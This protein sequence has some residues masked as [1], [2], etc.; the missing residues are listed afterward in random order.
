MADEFVTLAEANKSPE[1]DNSKKLGEYM[2]EII[3][4]EGYDVIVVGENQCA[5]MKTDRGQVSSFSKVIIDQLSKM[6]PYFEQ[7]KKFKVRPV[8][9]KRYHKFED[10]E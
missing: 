6:R 4:L 9:E 2:K 8:T 1:L 10:V 3:I 5:I 7:G